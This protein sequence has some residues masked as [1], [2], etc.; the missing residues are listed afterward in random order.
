MGVLFFCLLFVFAGPYLW[1][2][3]HLHGAIEISRV[4]DKGQ[5]FTPLSY[6]VLLWIWIGKI[7]N[8][9][10]HLSQILR[11]KSEEIHSSKREKCYTVKCHLWIGRWVE[12]LQHIFLHGNLVQRIFNTTCQSLT[13][14]INASCSLSASVENVCCQCITCVDLE[15]IYFARGFEKG[16]RIGSIPNILDQEFEESVVQIIP[17]YPLP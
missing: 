12:I 11:K 1:S 5:L 17:S 2:G 6:A 7:D 13:S 15:I 8:L 14:L 9:F 10:L 16:L 4:K 3:R